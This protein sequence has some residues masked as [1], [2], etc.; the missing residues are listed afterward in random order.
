[1]IHKHNALD[2]FVGNLTLIRN[3][4]QHWNIEHLKGHHKRVATIED[5]ATALLNENVFFF[6]YKS[7][8]GGMKSAWEIEKAV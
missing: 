1:M 4:L 8:F 7:Y 6:M 5:P 3:F 2:K